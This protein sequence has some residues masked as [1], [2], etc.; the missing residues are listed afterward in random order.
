MLLSATL[1]IM[2]FFNACSTDV[3]LYA[4]YKDITIVYGVLDADADTNFVKINKAF[5]GPGDATH[6]SQIPDSSNYPGKL[7]ARIVEYVNGDINRE[8]ILDTITIHD[9]DSGDFYA[10]NQLLYYTTEQIHAGS[11]YEYK[12]IINKTN[13]TVTATTKVVGG[14][15]FNVYTGIMNFSSTATSGVVK[16]YPASNAAMYNVTFRFE[17]TEVLS[18]DSTNKDMEWS[19]GTFAINDLTMEEGCFCVPYEPTAFFNYLRND[20]GADTITSSKRYVGP[21][22][23]TIAAGGTELYNYI[24]VNEPSSSIVQSIPEYTNI[25]G[26]YGVFSSRTMINRTVRLSSQTVTELYAKGWGFVQGK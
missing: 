14:D 7:D 25:N 1:A 11:S 16:W 8:L 10:P 20:L 17:Y 3:D 5:L 21:F 19:L 26:G 2:A 4:D 9:K 22:H 6:I 23:I 13:D 12:L 18:G 24:S 15:G